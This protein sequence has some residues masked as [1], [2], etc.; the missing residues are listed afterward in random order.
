MNFQSYTSFAYPSFLLYYSSWKAILNIILLL[1]EKNSNL[2]PLLSFPNDRLSVDFLG[3]SFYV[4]YSLL[5]V[6]D[7]YPISI[8]LVLKVSC[9]LSDFPV[10]LFIEMPPSFM[11]SGNFTRKL[12]Y[13]VGKSLVKTRFIPRLILEQLENI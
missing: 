4:S 13:F 2:L 8:T 9:F 7:I 11:L 3:I 10:L 6:T 5:Y 1:L 12:L